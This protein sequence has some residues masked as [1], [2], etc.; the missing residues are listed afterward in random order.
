MCRQMF[1][2]NAVRATDNLDARTS[3]DA[4]IDSDSDKYLEAELAELFA[5]FL[6][7]QQDSR[8]MN[9]VSNQLQA[10]S[11]ER[12]ELP[13][14]ARYARKSQKKSYLNDG[15]RADDYL[16]ALCED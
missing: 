1:A 13:P 10:G 8:R 9:A 2:E 15:C 11:I 16:C 4:S 5:C 6:S 3:H 14:P 12:A 7:S